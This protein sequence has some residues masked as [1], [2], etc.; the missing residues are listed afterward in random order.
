MAR[1]GAAF[2]DVG[3]ESTRPGAE[4]V[5]VETEL[6]RVLP[7]IRALSSALPGR[8]SVDTYKA[9]VAAQALAAG[10]YMVNDIS[11]LRMDPDMVAVV[12]DAG[13]PVVLMHML[14]RAEDHAG[15]ARSTAMSSKSCTSS[16]WSGSTGP[17]TRACA[18][19]TCSSTRASASARPRP[20]T[21]RY[22]AG[23]AAFRSLGQA[24]RGGDVAQALPGR[25]TRHR[26]IRK[27]RD[28]ATAATTVMAVAAG[29]HIVRVHRVGLNRDAARVARAVWPVRD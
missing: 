28:E 4:A 20:T 13:C 6:G 22:C 21:W 7:V 8:V 26:R 29:A 27:H 3:G 2:V 1:D 19:R 17:W 16:S 23:L 15:V 24:D 11:A 14:G 12:R 9:T 18:R 10:A 5:P 25:D